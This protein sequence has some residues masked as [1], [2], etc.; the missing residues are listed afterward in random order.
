MT[1]LHSCVCLLLMSTEEGAVTLDG[2]LLLTGGQTDD[3]EDLRSVNLSSLGISA[4]VNDD[5][6]FFANLKILDLSDNSLPP[7]TC[8]QSLSCLPRLTQLNLACNNLATFSLPLDEKPIFPC[9]EKLDLSFNQLQGET[10][11]A[12]ALNAPRLRKLDLSH[13][14]I[15]SIATEIQLFSRLTDLNLDANDLVQYDQWRALELLPLLK[16]LSLGQNRIRRLENC[17]VN[18]AGQS[19]VGFA[20]LEWL[21]LS[22]NNIKR[23]DDISRVIQDLPELREVSLLRNPASSVNGPPT[24]LLKLVTVRFSEERQAVTS[25]FDFKSLRKVHPEPRF[26]R[27]SNA[28]LLAKIMEEAALNQPEPKLLNSTEFAGELKSRRAR[29]MDIGKNQ[30]QIPINRDPGLVSRLPSEAMNHH[31]MQ[32]KHCVSASD[33]LHRSIELKRPLP[34]NPKTTLKARL[35]KTLEWLPPM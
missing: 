33:R 29:V 19:T 26:N 16:R 17:C 28:K 3:P 5:L 31:C 21:D 22:D 35:D 14:C 11:A 34:F 24:A 13:N 32:L 9:L 25:L 12:L 7:E 15:S 2:F 18:D 20:S 1:N 30:L 23:I 10:L 8:M 6:C 27:S 4:I